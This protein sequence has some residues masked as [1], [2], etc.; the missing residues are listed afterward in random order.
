MEAVH[1]SNADILSVSFVTF[2]V[3]A[4]FFGVISTYGVLPYTMIEI[5]S[6]SLSCNL[7]MKQNYKL[8][9]FNCAGAR[10]QAHLQAM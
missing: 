9:A 5:S 3:A 8:C 1:R 7:D 6:R 4:I 2:N 10:N